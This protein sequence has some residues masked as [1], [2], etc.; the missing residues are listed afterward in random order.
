MTLH[1]S[2]SKSIFKK[3]LYSILLIAFSFSAFGQKKYQSLLWEITGNGIEKPS[4][5]YGTMHISGRLAFHLGEEFFEAIE[6]TDAVALESN[7]IIWLDEIFASPYA[8]DY[9]G[10]YG[11]KYQT[12]K[13]FYQTAFGLTVPDNKNLS[14]AISGDHYLSNW[15][16][17]RENKSKLDFQEETFLDLFIYQTGLK[18][19]REVYSLEN[20]SQTTHFSKMGSMPDA[21]KKEKDAWY[22]ALTEEKNGNELITEAYRNKESFFN[23][24]TSP[25]ELT[26]DD[27]AVATLDVIKYLIANNRLD[28]RIAVMKEGMM[29]AKIWLFSTEGGEVAIHGS[30]NAT[31]PSDAGYFVRTAACATDAEPTPASLEKAARWN[32]CINTPKKP[33]VIPA[34]VNA[35]LKI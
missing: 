4:Y 3:S 14:A 23:Y 10:K 31:T 1:Y 12:Y 21:E 28:I 32:P 33:P 16:L 9:L 2:Y 6:S 8:D 29:H 26:K 15:M 22:E 18:S 30:S 5:L 24:F 20:F 17:Y 25:N 34:P 7:P 19:G 11:F 27:L 35:P 13:G